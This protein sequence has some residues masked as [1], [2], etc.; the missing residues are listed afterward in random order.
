VVKRFQPAWLRE[1]LASAPP[2]S[3]ERLLLDQGFAVRVGVQRP[4]ASPATALAAVAVV[5][6][7]AAWLLGRDFRLTPPALYVTTSLTLRRNLHPS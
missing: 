4:S 7:L 6:F 3:V 1:T 2:G 5:L